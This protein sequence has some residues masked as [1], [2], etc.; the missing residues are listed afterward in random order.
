MFRCDACSSTLGSECDF[1]PTCAFQ[2]RDSP[3]HYGAV[4]PDV[5]RLASCHSDRASPCHTDGNI[6]SLEPSAC[7]IGVDSVVCA[8]VCD[9]GPP[10]VVGGMFNSQQLTVNGVCD[11]GLALGNPVC[12]SATLHQDV[13]ANGVVPICLECAL[14]AIP[15]LCQDCRLTPPTEAC[16]RC[17]KA[18]C[19][20]CAKYSHCIDTRIGQCKCYTYP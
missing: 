10:S 13:C 2:H 16:N 11:S 15:P 6:V 4:G 7:E 18:L 3:Y 8:C 1:T 19:S 12:L 5:D 20:W 17:F 14:G 9:E